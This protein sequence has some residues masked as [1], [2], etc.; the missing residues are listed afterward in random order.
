[1]ADD[2]DPPRRF[3]EFKPRE[4]ER[5]NESRPEP[6]PSVPSIPVPAPNPSAKIDIQ[7]V[8]RQAGTPGPVLRTT[9]RVAV[10]NEVHD[11]LRDNTAR[12]NAA[13]LNT[14]RPK[15]R[16]QSRRR[17][18]Y[19]LVMIGANVPMSL[20]VIYAWHA[21]NPILFV[22]TIAGMGLFTVGISWVMWFI[23]EDY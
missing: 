9:P 7:E 18:D 10:A 22:Y 1:M 17:R 11:I 2:P 16:R 5:A 8:I 19:F 23:M 4:F 3:Y 20:V 12:D 14:L 15:P 21:R 13:G 6:Q